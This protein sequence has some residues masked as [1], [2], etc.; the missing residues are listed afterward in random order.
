MALR[1][2]IYWPMTKKAL[3]NLQ[4]FQLLWIL[5]TLFPQL[6]IKHLLTEQSTHH[7]LKSAPAY[8]SSLKVRM[9]PM[10]H[11]EFIISFTASALC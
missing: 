2:V 7:T 8:H 5:V 4:H 3:N 9:D 1:Q 11:R 10:L 6:T